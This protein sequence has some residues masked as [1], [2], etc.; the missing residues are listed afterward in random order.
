MSGP[1]GE[2]QLH[3]GRG[4]EEEEEEEEGFGEAGEKRSPEHPAEGAAGI[5][6]ANSPGVP[7]AAA[8]GPRWRTPESPARFLRVKN[9]TLETFKLGGCSSLA[10]EVCSQILLNPALKIIIIAE[11]RG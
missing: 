9:H 8:T 4:G 6:P 10:N 7:T 11:S 5:E 3:L 2:P 1:N